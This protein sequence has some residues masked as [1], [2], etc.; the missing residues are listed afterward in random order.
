MTRILTL[1]IAFFLFLEVNG[2][3]LGTIKDPDGYT[4]LREEPS[5]KSKIVGQ[6]YDDEIF[7]IGDL[8]YDTIPNWR[9]VGRWYP[10][11]RESKGGWM[12]V[13]RIQ[14]LDYLPEPV[15]PKLSEDGKILTAKNDT[16]F[17]QIVFEDF[18]STKHEIVRSEHGYIRTI[19]GKYP[20]GTD[21]YMPR[22]GIKSVTFQM[23]GK[24]VQFPKEAYFDPFISIPGVKI[25]VNNVNIPILPLYF[26][27]RH[28]N[29]LI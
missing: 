18:D 4:N 9:K 12:H 23:N 8:D 20:Q 1:I 29:L 16:I 21:G 17:F 2:Q 15:R 13:S 6:F 27:S 28:E 14:D 25:D 3:W 19:D 5:I 24:T 26:H 7:Q 10:E 11:R 22:E